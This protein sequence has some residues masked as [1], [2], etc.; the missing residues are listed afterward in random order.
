MVKN[1][2]ITL[3]SFGLSF[4]IVG[5]TGGKDQTNIELV[6]GMMDQ[7][8]FKS[9]DWDPNSKDNR[10]MMVPPKNTVPRGFKPYKYSLNPDGAAKA[11][12]NPLAGKYEPYILEAGRKRFMVYCAVC[13]GE[14][15]DGKGII[16][17]HLVIK[18]PPSLLSDK[19]K[20]YSDGRIYHVIR[21]GYG[22]MGSYSRQILKDEDRWAVVN[23]LRTLQKK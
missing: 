4:L 9:Q 19:I 13:H 17:P 16:A 12:K 14:K 22:M 15:A 18:A 11:L 5:C 3:T 20:S 7:R 23:Y 2:F 10:S 1:I 21:D 8:S 6:T